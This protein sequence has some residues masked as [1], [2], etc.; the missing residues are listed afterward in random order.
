[1]LRPLFQGTISRQIAP[2][3]SQRIAFLASV[4][5]FV[6]GA[7]TATPHASTCAE[8]SVSSTQRRTM[9]S[10]AGSEALG[11][12]V[13]IRPSGKHSASVIWMHGLGDTGEGWSPVMEQIR[14]PDVKY[15]CPTAPRIPV[16]LNGGYRMP[17]WYA[18][19]APSSRDHEKCSHAVGNHLANA[20]CRRR[21]VRPV[22][23]VRQVQRGRD[24]D[25]RSSVENSCSY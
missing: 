13:V 18:L 1:M 2:V 20:P 6:A 11:P 3:L 12:P 21:Q 9:A 15:I 10:A 22:R 5:A 25:R 23:I 4:V 17:A 14:R 19:P 24:R 8:A 7:A 16:T